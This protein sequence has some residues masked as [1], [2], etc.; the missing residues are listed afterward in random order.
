MFKIRVKQLEFKK[1]VA[2]YANGEDLRI[3][4]I[5]LRTILALYA[6]F[7]FVLGIATY[8]HDRTLTIIILVAMV[9]M[10]IPIYLI[11]R[12]QLNLGNFVL[13]TIIVSGMTACAINGQGIH[14]I[15]IMTFPVA[16]FFA[17]LVLKRQD[18]FR[19]SIMI[20]AAV[21]Y[22]GLGQTFGWLPTRSYTTPVAVDFSIAL[23]ILVVAIIIADELAQNIRENMR[24]AQNEIALREE[25]Q[26]QLHHLSTHDTLTQIY[27]RAFFDE[28]LTLFEKGR[29]FPVSILFIDVD[30]L[31]TINDQQG[32]LVGDNLLKQAALILSAAFRNGDILA[33]IGGDEFAVILPQTDVAMA[34]TILNR[35]RTALV[36][37]NAKN[38]PLP[39]NLS[40]G[41]ATAEK[42]DLTKTLHEADRHMYADKAAHKAK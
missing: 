12:G 24:I 14:D 10:A 36:E 19:I 13:L 31:K 20:A 4:G 2:I 18:Y 25:T 35:V 39:I 26:E 1:L 37:H 42:G 8:T 11:Y 6:A 32:H 34:N 21:G 16:V 41:V 38:P 15:A 33:R 7:T 29:E 40:L 22:L 17:N 27:N 3:A 5:V 9:L 30:G 23:V 28:M